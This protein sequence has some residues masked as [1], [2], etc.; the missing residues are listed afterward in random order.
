MLGSVHVS[1]A[2]WKESSRDSFSRRPLAYV[3]ACVVL[4]VVGTYHMKQ[5]CSAPKLSLQTCDFKEATGNI[6]NN[7]QENNYKLRAISAP[8]NT[9]F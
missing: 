4:G 7:K 5:V 8:E 3:P 6:I 1:A 9:A 2:A